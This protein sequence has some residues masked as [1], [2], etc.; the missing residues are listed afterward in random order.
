MDVVADPSVVA[1]L[2]SQPMESVWTTS[3]TIFELQFGLDLL[4]DN[5]KRRHLERE[6]HRLISEDLENQILDFDASAAAAAGSLAANRQRKGTSGDV[7]D[8]LI[9]GI[10]LSRRATLAT[11]NVRHFADLDATVV[12]PWTA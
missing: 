3:I 6:F 9:A 4:P 5:R 2:D 1:W 10:V 11:R 12:N 8:T 7:R